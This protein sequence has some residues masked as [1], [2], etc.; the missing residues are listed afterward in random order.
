MTQ[1]IE[2]HDIKLTIQYEY[3]F[4]SGIYLIS[5]DREELVIE[6]IHTEGDIYTL[7][8][9]YSKSIDFIETIKEKLLPYARDNSRN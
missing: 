6:S 1:T 8:E 3:Y 4:F 7:L 5:P 9:N 2:L